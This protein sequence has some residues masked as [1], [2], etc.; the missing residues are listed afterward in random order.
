VKQFVQVVG[1]PFSPWA[2]A[3]PA[4]FV[5]EPCF[6]PPGV[7]GRLGATEENPDM[8][9]S[10]GELG[11]DWPSSKGFAALPITFGVDAVRGI[12]PCRL[13]LPFLERLS[14]TDCADA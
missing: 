11:L 2:P 12:F 3:A 10:G 14:E 6:D 5:A 4:R 13:S 1:T 7:E 8:F 9:P